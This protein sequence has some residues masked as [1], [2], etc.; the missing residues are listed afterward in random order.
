MKYNDISESFDEYI[1]EMPSLPV[2]AGK[3]TEICNKASV[4]PSDLNR[5][6][7]LDP[8]LRGRLLQLF[9]SAYHV[10]GRHVTSTVKAVTM[11]GIN[12]VKNF[13]L[14]TVEAPPPENENA[15][16][17]MEDF[18]RHSLF[19]GVTA[20]QL[21]A[22]QNVDSELLGDYFTAGLLHDIGKIPLIAF[23]PSQY[24]SALAESSLEAEEKILG[25]NHCN[26]GVIIAA[27][28]KLDRPVADAI[29]HHHN[30]VSYSGENANIVYTVSIADYFS[31]C[32][33][34]KNYEKPA[35]KIW[36]ALNEKEDAFEEIKEKVT[37]KINKA[38]IF[39]HL[40][41]K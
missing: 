37:Q 22:R 16:L 5:L 18:W 8:V 1:K 21:A 34:N 28:W 25:I 13:V 15:P 4:N 36:Q 20:K 2:S 40:S 12:T 17:F 6:I 10:D 31:S 29:M 27:T 33:V 3:I 30:P 32:A 7:S 38:E 23:M 14:S 39:L 9:N 24:K 26:A 11:L 19:V 35:A 41:S